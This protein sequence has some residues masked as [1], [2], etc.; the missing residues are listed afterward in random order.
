MNFKR[1]KKRKM[2]GIKERVHRTKSKLSSRQSSTGSYY[3]TKSLQHLIRLRLPDYLLSHFNETLYKPKFQSEIAFQLSQSISTQNLNSISTHSQLSSLFN[4]QHNSNLVSRV[5]S[6]ISNVSTIGSINLPNLS[7]TSLIN[8]GRSTSQNNELT[9]N[10]ISTTIKS[11]GS[12]VNNTINGKIKSNEGL[13]SK[14]ASKSTPAGSG[15]ALSTAYN[16]QNNR[17][18]NN[19]K[20]S[21]AAAA[22]NTTSQNIPII[23]IQYSDSTT[24]PITPS[25]VTDNNKKLDNDNDRRKSTDPINLT[26]NHKKAIQELHETKIGDQS[27]TNNNTSPDVIISTAQST[28]TPIIPSNLQPQKNINNTPSGVHSPT[29][30]SFPWFSKLRASRRRSDGPG[31][32]SPTNASS[33]KQLHLPLTET[34]SNVLPNHNLN[35]DDHD[36]HP[37]SLMCFI[38]PK[39]GGSGSY[40]GVV[41]FS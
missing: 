14:A 28:T 29:H 32:H 37:L 13:G 2:S 24:K 12:K 39:S 22:E 33:T 23:S 34:K 4:S 9:A 15:T 19:N 36:I 5:N 6:Q 35:I 41:D 16:L 31:S 18:N 3:E 40:V 27:T 7:S 21:V 26:E 10:I 8:S 17:I 20:S 38:N 1:K 30:T 11:D 25:T